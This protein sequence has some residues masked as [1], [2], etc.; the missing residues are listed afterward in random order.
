MINLLNI[1]YKIHLASCKDKA[2][3]LAICDVPYGIGVGKMAYLKEVNTTVKQKNGTRL[4]PNKTKKIYTNKDWDSLPPDQSYFDEICRVSKNQIIFGV[5]YVDWIGL[6][7]GR[8]KWIKC[9]PDGVSFKKYEMAYCSLIDYEMELP[10]MWAGMQQAKSL[11]E[12]TT[13]QGN[14]NKNEKRIHPT[15]KPVLL[16]QKLLQM[17]AAK[18]DK[19]IDTHGGSMSIALACYDMGFDLDLCEIDKEYFDKGKLRYESHVQKPN[20][21]KTL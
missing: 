19:I 16:Y 17:F 15:Q 7:G 2:Y 14:K 8:I 12:L 18:G 13:S 11:I 21:F 9:I 20:M 3:G 5:E 1:D 10:L 6:G 4:N